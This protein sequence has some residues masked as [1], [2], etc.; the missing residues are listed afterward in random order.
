MVDWHLVMLAAFLV[1]PQPPALALL[2]IVVNVHAHHGRDAREAVDHN[3]KQG[4]IAQADQIRLF[5]CRAVA[6][7]DR[8]NERNAIEQ[9]PGFIR[10][11]N[12]RLAF[13]NGIARTMHGRSR[14]VRIGAITRLPYRRV[15]FDRFYG[16]WE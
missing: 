13:L 12:R 11:E 1:Q 15:A 7:R 9:Q 10:R 14:V 16:G 8:L 3:S 4:T 5:D 6:A 2:I